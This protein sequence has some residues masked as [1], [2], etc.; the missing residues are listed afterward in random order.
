MGLGYDPETKAQSSQWKSP[1]SELGAPNSEQ[2]Q[3]QV[4]CFFD[5]EGVV[6]HEY[7]PPTR[8]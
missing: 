8:Q 6:H 5:H 4:D 3:G 7:A 2:R 1:E